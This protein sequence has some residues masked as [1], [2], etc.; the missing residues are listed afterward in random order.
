MDSK[1]DTIRYAKEAEFLLKHELLDLAIKRI[2]AE[3]VESLLSCEVSELAERRADIVAIDKLKSKLQ[4][5][6]DGGKVIQT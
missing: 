1:D 4:G 6:F 3:A 5:F 2:R